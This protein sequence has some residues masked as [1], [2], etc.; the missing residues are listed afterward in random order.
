MLNESNSIMNINYAISI[1]KYLRQSFCF[2]KVNAH[3]NRHRFRF[4]FRVFRQNS[5]KRL[6]RNHECHHYFRQ[7]IHFL[8]KKISHDK[9]TINSIDDRTH[10]SI[11]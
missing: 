2:E 5:I 9:R 7:K 4:D 1:F 8:R 3:Y 11:A 10:N 6:N